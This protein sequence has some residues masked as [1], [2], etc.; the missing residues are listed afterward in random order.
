[1]KKYFLF[2]LDG[3]LADTGQGITECVQYALSEL[4]WTPQEE[5][6]LRQFVGPPL[7]DSFREFC[8]MG[9]NEAKRAIKFTGS[10]ITRRGCIRAHYTQILT[11]SWPG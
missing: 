9:E 3:T 7:M 5:G 8:G 6:F 4:G 1:M 11:G 10:A 2:D